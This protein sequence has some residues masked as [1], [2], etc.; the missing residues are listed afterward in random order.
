MKS[1]QRSRAEFGNVRSSERRTSFKYEHRKISLNPQPSAEILRELIVYRVSCGHRQLPP[2]NVLRHAVSNFNLI[3]MASAI[4]ADG[5]SRD[6]EHQEYSH[7]ANI[8]T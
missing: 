2:E 8:G 3:E 5:P 6:A 7:H 1:I 4:V